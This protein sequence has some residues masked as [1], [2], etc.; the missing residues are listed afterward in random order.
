MDSVSVPSLLAGLADD[1]AR[2]R[3]LLS[4]EDDNGRDLSR[5]TDETVSARA[6]LPVPPP[7]EYQAKQLVSAALT[8]FPSD[9]EVYGKEL[10]ARG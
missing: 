2:G 8:N 6:V 4:R 3:R 5:C 7:D 10:R 1:V 9:G